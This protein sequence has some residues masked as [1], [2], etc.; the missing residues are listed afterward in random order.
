MNPV[1]YISK[2]SIQELT[3][4]LDAS[5][6]VSEYVQLDKRGGRLWACCPFHKEKTASFTVNPDLKTWYCFGCHKGGTIINFVMEMDKI[7]FPETIEL[8]A[9]K[10][11]VELAYENSGGG[12]YSGSGYSVEEE[13]KKKQRDALFELYGRI[14]GTFHHFLLKEPEARPAKQYIIS[15][16]INSEMIQRFGLGYSPR[17]RYWLHK[18]LSGKGYSDDFLTLSGLFSSR[19]VK[20]SLFSGRLMFP[21]KD[22]KGRTVAFGGRYLEGSS[23]ERSSERSSTEG[24]STETA[25]EGRGGWK[26]PKYINSPELGIYKKGETLF[27]LDLAMPE[28]RRTKTAYLAEGYMDVMALHHAGLC[29]AIAPLGTAFTDEQ[30]KLLK[31][32]VEKLVLFFDF[33]EAGQA[34][35]Q[36]GVYTCR[37][38]GLT[39]AVVVP[40]AGT[41]KDPAEIL[42]DDGP[43]ALQKKAQNV[44]A[45]FD[46]LISRARLLL[47]GSGGKAGAVA[48]LFRYMELLDS[49]VAR[50]SCIE[51]AADAFG[52]LP[53]TVAGDFRR[54][55]SGISDRG[56][57]P[58]L[59]TAKK[60]SGEKEGSSINGASIHAAPIQMNEELSLLIAVALDYVTS[61][62]EA[63]L[64]KLRSS[65]EIN[66]V[67]D[68][69]ARDVYIALEE[70][71][72]YGEA[73]MDELLA[74]ISSPELQKLVVKTGVSGE[75]SENSWQFLDDS[76]KK[77]KGKDLERRQEEI[78]IKLRSIKTNSLKNKENENIIHELLSE[79]MQIDSELYQLK[80][81]RIS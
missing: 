20:A 19:D 70:C 77:I 18:F 34:A 24:S 16:G 42:N 60:P 45:D 73:G 8:L 78:I 6:V 79:K 68:P 43:E 36:K 9:K 65:L 39:C 28:M 27:A 7:T 71:F 13:E 69:N 49:E 57:R 55:A 41:A 33:D 21:I 75:F 67:L 35:A 17:D 10:F 26:P 46:Y 50:V 32:W 47:G 56:E 76:I 66:E 15:R 54:Y 25:G 37:K 31:R 2:S 29:N 63:M 62:N 51:A 80:Q 4:R 52:L 11:G 38:Y 40:D 61:K 12:N 64:S 3:D 5:A 44:L 72:R 1:P 74:R 14:S 81:G 48:F 53:A 30:A 23:I 22:Y 58:S 59:E